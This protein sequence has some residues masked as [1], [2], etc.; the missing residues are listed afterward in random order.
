MRDRNLLTS[1]NL[2]KGGIWEFEE[3]FI[4]GSKNENMK[5]HDTLWELNIPSA[6]LMFL[7]YIYFYFFLNISTH[8][9]LYQYSKPD[10]VVSAVRPTN[11]CDEAREHWKQC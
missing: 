8:L 5:I 3:H 7:F 4:G 10:Q 2:G 9:I 6:N 1:G 11:T